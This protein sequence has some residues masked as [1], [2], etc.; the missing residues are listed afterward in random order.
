MMS[1]LIQN[2][3]QLTSVDTM[4]CTPLHVAAMRSLVEA[5]ALLLRYGADESKK[6]NLGKSPLDY[7][8]ES[9]H[10]DSVTLLRLSRISKE[11]RIDNHFSTTLTE[12]LNEININFDHRPLSGSKSISDM[13]SI[14]DEDSD[15]MST[16]RQV[17]IPRTRKLPRPR[18]TSPESIQLL[19]YADLLTQMSSEL[20]S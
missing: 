7:A 17:R 11:D 16:D 13:T 6:D 20:T 18:A 2:G 12:A 15:S 14:L 9:E 8:V 3:V 19:K 10:A 5:I 4:G 1:F